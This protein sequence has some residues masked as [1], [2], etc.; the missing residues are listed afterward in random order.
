MRKK[1]LPY[2][3]TALILIA[4]LMLLQYSKPKNI[5]W[6]ESYVRTHKIPY[7][8]FVANELIENQLFQEKVQQVYLPPYE[9]LSN[10]DSLNG[11]YVFVNNDVSFEKAELNR[12]LNWTALGNTLFIASESFEKKFRDT[13]NFETGVVYG[14]FEVAQKQE[15]QLVNPMLK[16]KQPFTYE[17]ENYVTVFNEIDSVKMSVLATVQTPK[18][19]PEEYIENITAVKRPFGKGEIILSTFP[20]AFTNYFILEKDN[21]DYTAGLFSYFHNREKIYMDNYHKSG[22]AFYTSPMYIFL[23]TKELKWA[24]Y[25]ILIG[26]LIY[27]IF[28][29]K[30]KQRPIP[31][32]KPLQNQTMAFTRTISDM[33]FEKGDRNSIAEH[34]INYFLNYIKSRYYLTNISQEDEFYKKISGRSGNTIGETKTLFNFMDELRNSPLVSESQLI[35]LNKLIQKFKS[36]SDGK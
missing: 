26:G 5:N 24:Y 15:H 8:T 13:L 2:I 28:E 6:F 34:K 27:I 29:G 31:V 9:F 1:G 11:I 10:N 4:G 33:Y 21:K 36:D 23:N 30:R 22:K 18:D 7:G 19:K 16:G 3:I 35:K 12:L 14:G 25:L 20:K 17:K 32:V